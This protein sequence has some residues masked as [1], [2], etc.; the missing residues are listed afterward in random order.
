MPL[1]TH[2]PYFRHLQHSQQ[3]PAQAHD[4]K[5]QI[6]NLRIYESL[7]KSYVHKLS[8]LFQN[9]NFKEPNNVLLL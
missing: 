5:Q 7:V 3:H 2:L 1:R 6:L 4:I 8:F 9:Q